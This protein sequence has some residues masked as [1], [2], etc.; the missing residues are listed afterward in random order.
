MLFTATVKKGAIVIRDVPLRDG[1]VVDVTIL[2]HGGEFE[3]T[4]EE[5]RIFER[6][7]AEYAAAPELARPLDEFLAELKAKD[8]LRDQ[9]RSVGRAGGRTRKAK[10]GTARSRSKPAASRARKSK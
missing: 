10:L 4:A 8:V 7:E 3:P 5:I 6:G 2:Q 1:E 9:A